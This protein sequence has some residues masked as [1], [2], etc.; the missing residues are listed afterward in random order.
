MVI[1]PKD[2]QTLCE[3]LDMTVMRTI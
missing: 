2:E 3:P 1:A